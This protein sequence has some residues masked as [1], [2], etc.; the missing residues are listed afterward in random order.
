MEKPKKYRITNRYFLDIISHFK[1]TKLKPFSKLDR[2]M[3]RNV[4]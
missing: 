3:F 1:S 2:D 4:Q